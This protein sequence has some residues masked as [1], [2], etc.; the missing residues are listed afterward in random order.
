MKLHLYFLLKI[1]LLIVI[2]LVTGLS[3]QT[4]SADI[5]EDN[6]EIYL[7]YYHKGY[8]AGL[9]ENDA[10]YD[11]GRNAGY[12]AA[13]AENAAMTQAAIQECINDLTACSQHYGIRNIDNGINHYLKA[14]DYLCT[15][16]HTVFPDSPSN[17]GEAFFDGS[18]LYF[19]A[20]RFSGDLLNIKFCYI[21]LGGHDFYF[22]LVDM[23]TTQ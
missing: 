9:A 6:F 15:E 5:F 13:F 3:S 20:I 11:A 22:R 18:A 8:I 7:R 21:P 16:A 17:G 4:I 10:A 2:F 12:E 23:Q 19:N 14:Q 1:K